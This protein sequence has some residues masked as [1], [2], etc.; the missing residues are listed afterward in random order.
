MIRARAGKWSFKNAENSAYVADF[1]E[2]LVAATPAT[3]TIDYILDERLREYYGEGQRW[4]ELVR[5]QTWIE[6]AASF[7]ICG[8]NAGDHTPKTIEREIDA[9]HYLRPIPTGQIDGM[10]MDEAAKAA[11][12]NPGY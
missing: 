1:S 9:H 4:F 7:T 6:R 2:E 8:I 10:V 12:Q 3:I 5:T 11:Y